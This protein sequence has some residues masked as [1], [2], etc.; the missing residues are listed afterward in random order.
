MYG[1]FLKDIGNTSLKRG[2]SD[3]GISN[4]AVSDKAN[5]DKGISNKSDF[6]RLIAYSPE[7][8]CI[9]SYSVII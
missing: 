4:K 5:P 7:I 3:K 1:M 2:F 8:V 9:I 6:K